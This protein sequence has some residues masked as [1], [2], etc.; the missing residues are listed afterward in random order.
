MPC[1]PCGKAASTTPAKG[2]TGSPPVFDTNG[3]IIVGTHADDE[4]YRLDPNDGRVLT[5]Y[6]MGSGKELVVEKRLR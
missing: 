3:D 2:S 4:L 6:N 5:T 1:K